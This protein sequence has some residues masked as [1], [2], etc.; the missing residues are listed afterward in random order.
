M[1][2]LSRCTGY[3]FGQLPALFDAML[4]ALVI[5]STLSTVFLTMANALSIG[6]YSLMISCQ[7]GVGSSQVGVADGEFSERIPT[8]TMVS[9]SFNLYSLIP[10]HT[11]LNLASVFGEQDNSAS[12]TDLE[13]CLAL[14]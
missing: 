11:A 8:L 2:S 4:G 13:I 10:T 3:S 6:L 14:L 9:T 7:R 1:L 5:T 12:N